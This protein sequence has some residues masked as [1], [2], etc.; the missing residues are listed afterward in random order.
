M[1]TIK[2]KALSVNK[3]YQGRRF[4]TPE[5]KAYKQE[6]YLRLPPLKIPTG[7]LKIKYIFGVSSQASDLD[8]CIK[9]FQDALSEKYGFNDKMIFKMDAEKRITK[10][11]DEY[12]FFEINQFKK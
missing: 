6:L 11:G 3:S 12:I 10:K 9:S 2:I 5:L 7:K 1:A 8:N 4:A